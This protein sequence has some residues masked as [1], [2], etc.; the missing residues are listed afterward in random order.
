MKVKSL[1][2]L[3]LAMTM[4]FG[5]VA[6]GSKD[7][8]PNLGKYLCTSCSVDGEA[9]DTADQ[10]IELREGGET[11]V[12]LQNVEYGGKWS[13]DG[14]EL[15]IL[16][17]GSEYLGTLSEG[18]IY[19]EISGIFYTFQKEGLKSS[20]GSEDEKEV[21]SWYIISEMTKE[22]ET[23][24][25][26]D[27]AAHGMSDAYIVF[28]PDG[29]GRLHWPSDEELTY[30]EHSIFVSEQEYAYSIAEDTLTL[31]R[32]DG[33]A[34]IM[35]RGEGDPPVEE[36]DTE[37]AEKEEPAQEEPK[38][39]LTKAQQAWN[40]SWY[41]WWTIDSATNS[42]A[43]LKG[44]RWDICAEIEVDDENHAEMVVWDENNS[45]ND[46]LGTISML[47]EGAASSKDRGSAFSTSGYFGK[48]NLTFADWLVM[49]KH[50]EFE[51]FLVI[52]ARFEDSAGSYLYTVYLRP[53]GRD[54]EDVAAEFPKDI[55]A[56]YKDWYLPLIEAK[57]T[58]PSIIGEDEIILS[59]EKSK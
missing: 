53:W 25:A 54:W 43:D 58:M 3:L 17:G 4:L 51:D 35:K 48:Q 29:T 39:K 5:L 23:V 22:G 2:A 55:P 34:L 42:Y 27:L 24:S 12:F 16:H 31:D 41:G 19:I 30:D 20:D 40:G 33:T 26:E 47:V 10:W 21:A 6:C 9:L 46:P 8:D 15:T 14:E 59:A 32:G 7:D 13:L 37:V 57:H 38:K 44:S 18:V 36:A 49:T 11:A 50:K 45:R 1:L 52:C 56:N 28:H